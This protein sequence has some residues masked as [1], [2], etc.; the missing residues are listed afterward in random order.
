MTTYSKRMILTQVEQLANLHDIFLSPQSFLFQ[1][2]HHRCQCHLAD[3][4][5]VHAAL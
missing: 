4:A 2:H 3:K 1:M 5:Q